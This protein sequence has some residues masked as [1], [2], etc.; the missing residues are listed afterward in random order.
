MDGVNPYFVQNT[1]YYFW[2]VV[3]INNNISL[4]LSM[5]NEHLML[6]LIFP[7]IRQLKNMDV[8]LQP[9]V[10]ELKELWEGIHA[11]DVSRPITTER[12]FTLYGIYAY[13]THD[14]P[15]LGV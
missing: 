9:L 2:H 5:K 15:V 3:V 8:Y 1:N 13:K 14:Y 6:A 4:L 10:V 7:G 11:Y 12:S